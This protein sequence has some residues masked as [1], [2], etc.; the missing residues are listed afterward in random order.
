MIPHISAVCYR[1]ALY[2][3]MPLQI[4]E[5]I[6]RLTILA[7]SLKHNIT[8]VLMESL[9]ILRRLYSRVPASVPPSKN[10]FEK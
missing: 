8:G 9:L 4:P 6:K 5:V 2:Q 7:F 10:I 1:I 3:T